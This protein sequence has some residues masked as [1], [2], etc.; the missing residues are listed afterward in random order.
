[1]RTPAQPKCWTDSSQ[2]ATLLRH[3]LH[4]H[5]VGRGTVVKLAGSQT[6]AAPTFFGIDRV[7]PRRATTAAGQHRPTSGAAATIVPARASL[8]ALQGGQAGAHPIT[9]WTVPQ[10]LFRQQRPPGKTATSPANSVGS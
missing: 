2:R 6:A 8:A 3:H 1:M 4:R 9:T 5:G 10:P 7:V